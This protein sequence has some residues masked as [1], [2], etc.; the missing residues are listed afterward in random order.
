V[1]LLYPGRSLNTVTLLPGQLFTT[2]I[3]PSGLLLTTAALPSGLLLST[4][5]YHL[6]R[7]LR[8]LF[9]NEVDM[10]DVGH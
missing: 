3:L 1:Q 4:V 8:M 10:A 5:T 7:F 2:V 9:Q 6:V